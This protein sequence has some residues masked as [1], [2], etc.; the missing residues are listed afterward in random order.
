ML[1]AIGTGL[2]L[3][4]GF[5]VLRTVS[6]FVQAFEQLFDPFFRSDWLCFVEDTVFD[7]PVQVFLGG[8]VDVP[9]EKLL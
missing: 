1:L 7:K 2:G 8:D 6:D 5:G 9:V 4:V 3:G